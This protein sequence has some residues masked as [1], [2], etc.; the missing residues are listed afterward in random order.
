M[1]GFETPLKYATYSIGR[2]GIILVEDVGT[3][4]VLNVLKRTSKKYNDINTPYLS[5]HQID[6]NGKS[7]KVS[8]A[9]LK[10][11]VIFALTDK[12]FFD[13]SKLSIK[14]LIELA[15]F[16]RL[17]KKYIDIENVPFLKESKSCQIVK[18]RKAPNSN[19]RVKPYARKR[20]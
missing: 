3:E 14:A 17:P 7:Y 15:V 10:D 19:K 12:K 2:Q 18:G 1:K 8:V 9:A 5:F 4:A 20:K 13:R 6:S 11:S 16:L